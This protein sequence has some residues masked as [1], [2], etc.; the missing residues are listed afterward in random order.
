[1]F[2]QLKFHL[3]VIKFIV[4]ILLSKNAFLTL[5]LMLNK[6]VLIFFNNFLLV[7]FNDVEFS[8]I[9]IC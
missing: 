6:N 1:V 4:L 9:L 7:D 8:I 3:I 2:Q 5:C